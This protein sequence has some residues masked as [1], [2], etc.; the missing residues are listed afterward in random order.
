VGIGLPII[1]NW[2]VLELNP[3]RF[4]FHN[5]DNIIVGGYH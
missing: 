3:D 5:N 4:G 2:V 1:V